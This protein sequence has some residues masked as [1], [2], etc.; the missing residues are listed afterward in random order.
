MTW[1]RPCYKGVSL[2]S[3]GE[4]RKIVGSYPETIRKRCWATPPTY[5]PQDTWCH[6]HCCV[7]CLKSQLFWS[8]QGGC[9][10]RWSIGIWMNTLKQANLSNPYQK[11]ALSWLI[12]QPDSLSR[13]K[14]CN[15]RNCRLTEGRYTHNHI[16]GDPCH[17]EQSRSS[18]SQACARNI[19]SNQVRQLW[20]RAQPSWQVKPSL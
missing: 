16:H 5:N 13:S 17:Q 14:R 19:G 2:R 12:T 20:W 18:G 4:S 15:G 10:E 9:L 7:W 11:N 1:W 8:H 6:M 3:R